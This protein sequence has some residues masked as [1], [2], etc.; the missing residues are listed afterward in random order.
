MNAHYVYK[1]TN[2]EPTDSRKYYIGVHTC[3][4]ITPEED[5]KYMSSSKY[6]KAAI[7]QQGKEYFIKEILS[8]WES[9]EEANME[10]VRLHWFHNV[11]KHKEY[12]NLTNAKHGGFSPSGHV[13]VFDKT[14]GTIK[15]VLKEEFDNNDNLVGVVKNK[16]SVRNK[17]T[18]ETCQVTK[19][20]LSN[21]SNFEHVNKNKVLARDSRTNKTVSITK[22]EFSKYDYYEGIGKNTITVFDKITLKS[23]R[24]TKAEFDK[25]DNLVAVS[26]GTVTVK[27]LRDNLLKK[28]PIQDFKSF[29]YYVN[30]T[31]FI[32]HIFD[33]NNNLV[34]S[35]YKF[36]S[37]TCKKRGYPLIQFRWSYSNNGKPIYQDSMSKWNTLQAERNGYLQFKGWKAVKEN[38]KPW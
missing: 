26:K 36:F 8:I 23:K 11:A 29:D 33:N 22:E 27:D 24:V 30:Q 12:Y 5:T 38:Y 28:V 19:Q 6:L 1:I 16:V 35:I 10:E 7:K 18:G 15:I 34:E 14:D 2:I 25:L 20:E 32:V 4:N 9:R 21:N 13:T 17:I 31:S 37:E 3:E